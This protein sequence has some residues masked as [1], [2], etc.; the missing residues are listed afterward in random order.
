MV[1]NAPLFSRRPECRL[2]C[3]IMICMSKLIYELADKA[4]MIRKEGFAEQMEKIRGRGF[5]ANLAE[6]TE[7]ARLVGKIAREDERKRLSPSTR[8]DDTA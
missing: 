3:V 8:P 5:V 1:F 6:L 2:F 7:F 4:G